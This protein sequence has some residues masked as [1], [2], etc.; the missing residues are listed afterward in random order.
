MRP[1]GVV[2]RED[3]VEKIMAYLSLPLNPEEPADGTVVYDVT[4]DGVLA[5]PVWWSDDEAGCGT[6]PPGEWDGVDPPSPAG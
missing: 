1:I 4:G 3:A 6:G 5:S 2:E